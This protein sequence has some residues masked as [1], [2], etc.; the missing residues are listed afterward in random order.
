MV[1][2]ESGDLTA[3][4]HFGPHLARHGICDEK[5]RITSN[6]NKTIFFFE[7]IQNT[8]F[9]TLLSEHE[10]NE[11]SARTNVSLKELK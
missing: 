3:L 4:E 9:W 5:S 8:L 6:K 2:Q 1:F 11:F 7:N 10:Q